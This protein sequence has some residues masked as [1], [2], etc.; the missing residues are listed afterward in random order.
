MASGRRVELGPTELRIVWNLEKEPVRSEVLV[1][2]GEG[3]LTIA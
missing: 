3:R 2:D 1:V